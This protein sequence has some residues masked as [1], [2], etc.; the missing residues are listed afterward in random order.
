MKKKPVPDPPIHLPPK[1][2]FYTIHG[3]TTPLEAIEHAHRLISGVAATIDEH[4][5][6][7][8]REPGIEVLANVIHIADWGSSLLLFA[9]DCLT[10]NNRPTS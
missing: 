5:R 3:E 4:C 8:P 10:D 6:L 1:P 2:P 9:Q 7:Y